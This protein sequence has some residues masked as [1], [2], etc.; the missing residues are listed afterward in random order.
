MFF[1]NL[2]VFVVCL[3][4]V[5]GTF[6]DEFRLPDDRPL[7]E[8]SR[9]E[10]CGLRVL[11]SKHL[12]LVTDAPLAEVQD[13]PPLADALFVELQRQLGPLKPDLNGKN[14]QITGYVMGAKERF[15]EAGVLPPESIV[16][17][18]G[19][20]LGYQFWMNN[21]TLPYYRRHLLLHEFI[22]CFTMCEHGMAD[23]PPL[24][25]TEG[26][27]EYFA[28]H[29]LAADIKSTRFG[30]LPPTLDG[31]EGW[32][33]ITEIQT[34]MKELIANPA[35]WQSQMS[36]ESVRHPIDNNFTTDLQY[37]QAWALVW[38]IRN[39][40]E[41]KP[42]FSS[43]SKARTR[44]DFRDA[45]KSVPADVWQ[46]IAVI[47]P[48]FLTSLTEGFQPEHSFPPLDFAK[49]K[50]SAPGKFALQSNQEWQATGVSVKRGSTVQLTCS[51]RYAVHNKPR[52]WI[53]E[54]QGITIDYVYGRPLGE[55]TAILVAPDGSVCSGR[56][57]IGR[58]NLLTASA[59][60]ELWLQINDSANSRSDNSGAASIEIQVQ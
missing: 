9:L 55:V 25:Y 51:G 44:R 37:S 29:E 47:W 27:A 30:I 19:R 40:P 24:W 36:L 13:L 60:S 52:P 56:V 46:K 58:E 5:S 41:L 50:P 26:I 16:I 57:P 53:S 45:E 34:N 48:L 20:H 12:I 15:E 17:R 4:A 28:T 10:S 18:H 2:V 14:F 32:G 31:Y 54:P 6:A 49:L 21:Q 8:R 43:M 7:L 1:L 39:H 22:H 23:I 35:Q 33:R 11:E 38:L 59:D 3:E 42:H